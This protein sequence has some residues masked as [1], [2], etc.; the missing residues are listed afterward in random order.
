MF[1]VALVLFVLQRYHSPQLAGLAAFVSVIPG[2]IVS[3]LAGAL[4][5]RHGRARLVVLDYLIAGFMVALVAVLSGS[6]SLPPGLLLAIL[7]IGSLT[8]PLSN[9]GARSLFPLIAP[10]SLWSARTRWTAAA[11]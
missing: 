3:P 9:S 11:T 8:N 7:G 2:L 1:T 5:D 6:Q 4:L 10:P